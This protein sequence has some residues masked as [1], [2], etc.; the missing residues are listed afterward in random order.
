M[1]R[2]KIIRL[3]QDQ[4]VHQQILE[5]AVRPEIG[6]RI[7]QLAP[8]IRGSAAHATPAVLHDQIEVS[9]INV[10]HTVSISAT[11]WDLAAAGQ[12]VC[13][14]LLLQCPLLNHKMWQ[15]GRR[16]SEA[17]VFRVID[18]DAAQ[19][20]IGVCANNE[21]G[22]VSASLAVAKFWCV[23]FLQHEHIDV[24]DGA[25]TRQRIFDDPGGHPLGLLGRSSVQF[26]AGEAQPEVR[27][28]A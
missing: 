19:I 27:R 9:R 24:G 15:R 4:P 5:G 2:P 11:Q 6:S 23:L 10:G 26:Q 14:P 7:N 25:I 3:A 18:A 17:G 20:Q 16:Q 21:V 12:S 22:P 13:F 8:L 1:I 28:W